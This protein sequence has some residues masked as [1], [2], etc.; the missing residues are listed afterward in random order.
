MEKE[1]ALEII[2]MIADG[3]DPFG[4]RNP[5]TNISENNPVTIRALCIAIPSL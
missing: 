2:S 4:E 5:L 1:G 3:I